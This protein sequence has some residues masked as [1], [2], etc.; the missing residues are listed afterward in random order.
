MTVAGRPLASGHSH[1]SS[2]PDRSLIGLGLRLARPD[3]FQIFTPF[4]VC[5]RPHLNGRESGGADL[6]DPA[7]AVNGVPWPAPDLPLEVANLLTAAV[8]EAIDGTQEDFLTTTVVA[9]IPP[10][11]R[12]TAYVRGFSGRLVETTQALVGLQAHLPLEKANGAMNGHA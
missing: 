8:A 1:P 10:P 5:P 4:Y 12:S 9:P 6:S 2:L 3:L 7:R 11:S